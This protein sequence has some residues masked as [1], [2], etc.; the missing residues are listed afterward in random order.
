LAQPAG[1]YIWLKWRVG[2]KEYVTIAEHWLVAGAQKDDIVR[3]RDRNPANN[4]PDNL[5][6]VPV[7]DEAVAGIAGAASWSAPTAPRIWVTPFRATS[8][9]AGDRAH[10]GRHRAEDPSHPVALACDK[11]VGRYQERLYAILWRAYRIANTEA[12][13]IEAFRL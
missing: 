10:G 3:Q 11:A 6:L 9:H 7:H 13:A 5:L 2:L 4:D 12:A 1:I 8:C